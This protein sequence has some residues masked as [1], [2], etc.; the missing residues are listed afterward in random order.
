MTQLKITKE[1]ENPL[2]KRKE[3][4][5][6]I[7]AEVV[8]R[9]SEAAEMISKKFST[10][11][12]AIKIKKVSGRFGSK[13]FDIE[14]HIYSSKQEKDKIEVKTKQEKAAEAK[15]LEEAKKAPE[16]NAE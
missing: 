12:E 7:G 6:S 2:F 13:N 16:V 11:V 5:A 3:V 9:L 15:V 14:A 1:F 10:P 4:I 8:P